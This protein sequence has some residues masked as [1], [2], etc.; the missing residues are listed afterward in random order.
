MAFSKFINAGISRLGVCVL[1]LFLSSIHLKATFSSAQN[2][3]GSSIS[4]MAKRSGDYVTLTSVV[5]I[6]SPTV[7]AQIY[8]N[9]TGISNDYYGNLYAG[10]TSSGI[11]SK[12]YYLPQISGPWFLQGMVQ[13]VTN[14][15]VLTYG[16]VSL[17]DAPETPWG[18]IRSPG[19]PEDLIGDPVN[20]IN[21]EFYNTYD[22]LQ[23]YGAFPIKLGRIYSSRNSKI[24]EFGGGWISST[25]P[26]IDIAVDGST[27]KAA[28]EQGGITIFSRQGLTDVWLPNSTL[29]PEAGN[30]V[31]STVAPVLLSSITK[32]VVG[33]DTYYD[34]NQRNGSYR[35]Y[36][37][38]QFPVG[39]DTREFPYLDQAV[40]NR[41]NIQSFTFGTDSS[42]TDYGR[43]NKISNT[44]GDSVTFF[45]NAQGRL[46]TATANDGRVITYGYYSTGNLKDVTLADDAKTTYVYG[47]VSPG[48]SNHLIIKET[49]PDGRVLENEYDSSGRVWRQKATVDPSQPGVT[50]VNATFNYTEPGKTKLTDAYN[51]ET[52]YEYTDGLITAI[53]EPESRTTLKEWYVTTNSATGAYQRSLKKLTDPRGLV[54]EYKYDT[55]GNV[56]ETKLTG[57]LDGVATTTETATTT[58]QYTTLN[59]PDFIT[60]AAGRTTTFLYEDPLYPRLPT[61]LTTSKATTTLRV[62]KLV[63]TARTETI[64]TVTT[65]AKGLLEKR[66][67]AYGTADEA[68]TDYDYDATGFLTSEIRRSGTT[69]PDVT[70]T[71]TPTA[72]REIHTVTD[73]DN[74]QTL[75]T[76]DGLSRLKTKTVKNETGV[77]LGVWETTYTANG[78]VSRIDGPRSGPEDWAETDYD[79]AGRPKEH[80]VYRTQ[81]K[82]D[83][84][85]V[86]APASPANIA[87]TTYTHDLFGNLVK[88]V[89]PRGNAT[90]YT[91]D[92]VGRLL[93]KKTYSGSAIT[94]TPL[95]TEGTTYEP[96][97][98]PATITNALGG[99]TSFFYTASGK[100]RRQQN[101]D[102]SVQEWRYY[103][104]GRLFKEIL[105]NGTYWETSYDDLTRTITRTFKK[106]DA[107][108]LASE[109]RVYDRRGNLVQFTDTESHLH[110]TSYDDLDRPTV[111]TGPFATATS[112]QQTVTTFY[113]ASGKTRHTVNALGEAAVAT[114]DALGRSVLVQI[115]DAA[116]VVIR[117]T[118]YAYST[119]HQAV[120]ITEGTGAGA[121]VRTIYADPAGRTL[122]EIDGL[123][124]FTR[125][126]YDL[127][128]NRLTTTDP[129][130]RTTTWTYNALNQP[131]TQTL[132]GGNLTTFTH[133]AAGNLTHRE[134]TDGLTAEQLYDDAGR[135][136][137]SR[138]FNGTTVSR[139]FA[140]A[141]YPSTSPWAGLLQTTTAPRATVTT[142]YDDYLRP[143]TITSDGAA[144]ET[145]STTT[146]TYDKRGR[147]TSAAQSSPGDAAGPATSVT[148]SYDGYAHL[149]VETVAVTGGTSSTV[150]QH[151]DAAG[152]RAS[153]HET[154]AAQANPL[155]QYRHR[156]DGLLTSVQT[157]NHRFLDADFYYADT[158]L[159]TTRS[160]G[161]RTQ[162]ATSRDATGRILQQTTDVNNTNVLTETM[163]WR[164][165]GTLDTYD[166]SR[167]TP[168]VV[169]AWNEA[170]AYGYNDRGQV[171]SE[172]FSPAPGDTSALAYIFDGSSTAG[173]GI[174]TDAKVD[175]GA[176]AAWQSSATTVNNLARVTTD[177]TNAHGRSLATNGVAFGANYVELVVDGAAKGKA[178]HPGWADN[179]GAW[180]KTLTLDAGSHTLTANA[181]HPSGHFT[182]GA[183]STFTVNVPSVTVTSAYDAD[184]N[185]TSRTYS[186]GTVQTLTWDTFNRLIKVSE[187]DSSNNGY[188][189][190][191]VYDGLGRRLQTTQQP[192]AANSASGT[193]TV[194]AS[195]YDP[196]VEF[197]EIGVAING[198]KA[199]K[200][201]GLDLNGAYGGL[202]GTGGLE[203]TILDADGTVKAVVNDT[204]GNVIAT[205]T[206]TKVTW[207]PTRVGGYGPLPNIRAEVLSDITRVAEANA[208]RG[209]RIDPTGFYNLGARHYEPTSG[210]FLSPDPYGH[211][212]DM[213]LYSFAAGDAVNRFDPDGR[214]VANSYSLMG[215]GGA[216]MS[217]FANPQGAQALGNLMSAAQN[218][219]YNPSSVPS[220]ANNA[221]FNHDL[222]QTAQ[223]VLT[224]YAIAGTIATGGVMVEAAPA[225][226]TTVSN[227]ATTS[228][229]IVQFVLNSAGA[230]IASMGHTFNI[231]TIE[232][233]AAAIAQA[234]WLLP[235]TAKVISSQASNPMGSR[236]SPW[237]EL[238]RMVS[239]F[240]S[241]D[242]TT[243]SLN[244]DTPASAKK[245]CSK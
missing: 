234:P 103:A 87:T 150:T 32:A 18:P 180:S 22:D 166:V 139:P 167:N 170:R 40:D 36:R 231:A 210:R 129:L 196:L 146:Y 85:G 238:S 26:Y 109:T 218:A 184:G 14:G 65:F 215:M 56:T 72:R 105:R 228:G 13:H 42:A 163:T 204:F 233:Q 127:N 158:G 203:A 2:P 59:T 57:D 24:N 189:W 120:T 183:S 123:S 169:G 104:D 51:R 106:P 198:V 29:N 41:G 76:Y 49:K 236:V 244:L 232:I 211:A 188:D 214:Q 55:Q 70:L 156:A 226:T 176:P 164:D 239:D 101:P 134:M 152:R 34:W 151:W 185:V 90:G 10:W 154:S 5:Y 128:G 194:I 175:T 33:S 61:T 182:A 130:S 219:G 144:A 68:V 155:L 115:K 9:K 35:R 193:P 73:G 113:D 81:A 53:R 136:T 132:P 12:T 191:A 222:K 138:L 137:S 177:Q 11:Y 173:L 121:I 82:A 197:L 206:G 242:P 98:Q 240:F 190:T 75:F 122:L 96:G 92:N 114:S 77:T 179:V 208:W 7:Y 15:N 141:Y 225:L 235:A 99:V 201:Y 28:D 111:K 199:W 50:V 142:A 140:Y 162:T 200:V 6:G 213:S 212:T 37:V 97:G 8:I 25:T 220:A 1:T 133:D 16:R 131:L 80:R 172:G 230:D 83:G 148:R 241:P 147:L 124:K 4:V 126:T 66:T 178:S 43:I 187:R 84:S 160:N 217:G 23:T 181:V 245:G 149:L 168:N 86:E 54:T 69:A 209:R 192:I 143:Q 153:L 145:D 202:N 19:F 58:A 161:L 119:N 95:R 227:S 94:G 125:H 118:G 27:I 102:G 31:N 100:P 205:V 108:I 45:Y 88:T 60:D 30:A 21:G 117:Q 44:A 195:V 93:F 17:I 3:T 112:S 71:Y 171:T 157:Q 47:E 48:V 74:R 207:S 107:T 20:I 46:L 159:L 224:G 135:L 229:Q 223:G 62:D 186:N 110:A 116:N 165:D 52:I 67:V 221:Q 89:D 79:Q 63:Y 39:S 174:R 216:G 78:E 237:G 64:G 243:D 38:R 91:Y